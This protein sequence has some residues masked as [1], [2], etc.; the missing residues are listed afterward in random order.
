[1]SVDPNLPTVRAVREVLASGRPPREMAVAVLDAIGDRLGWLVGTLWLIDDG[2]QL[3]RPVTFWRAR[4]HK[5]EEFIRA[6]EDVTFSRTIGLPGRV[7]SHGEPVWITDVTRDGNFPRVEAARS[8]GLH[9][10]FAF[11]LRD[12]AGEV[13][14]V[15]DYFTD[16]LRSPVAA[17]TT[18]FGPL[19]REIGA[20]IAPLREEL[21]FAGNGGLPG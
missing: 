7:W 17:L 21:G 16:Q 19:G 18:I 2:T 4:V 14:G 10:A 20:A 1:M 15:V 8:E 11:P 13:I 12:A 3:L 6:T 9:G 5:R